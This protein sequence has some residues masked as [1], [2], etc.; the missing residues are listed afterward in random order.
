MKK[1]EYTQWSIYK[2]DREDGAS[3]LLYALVIDREGTVIEKLLI[4]AWSE[5]T[6]DWIFD[7][8]A[9]GGPAMPEG[10][11]ADA[12]GVIDVMCWLRIPTIPMTAFA[13]AQNIK[14]SLSRADDRDDN[15]EDHNESD[16]EF[17]PDD[18]EDD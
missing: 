11:S 6:Q 15:I 16:F 5:A 13:R 14:E 1:E 18:F 3:Y 7:R 2:M 10:L 8:D 4:A 12:D 9:E 17:E